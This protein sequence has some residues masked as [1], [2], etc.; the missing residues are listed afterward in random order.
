MMTVNDYY[1]NND[2]GDDETDGG[3]HRRRH[4]Q[5]H[6]HHR[7]SVARKKNRGGHAA[8]VNCQRKNDI[9]DDVNDV[10]SVEIDFVENENDIIPY[11]YPVKKGDGTRLDQNSADD[12]G[13]AI[14]TNFLNDVMT[15]KNGVRV[16]E[17]KMI[18]YLNLEYRGGLLNDRQIL[19]VAWS[20]YL[21]NYLHKVL[22]D[23]GEG[24]DISK[25]WDEIKSLGLMGPGF[26]VLTN[27]FER[28]FAESVALKKHA[29]MHDVMGA[30][31]RNLKVTNGYCYG[32]KR[33][34]STDRIK[35]SPLLGHITGIFKVL[36]NDNFLEVKRY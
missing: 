17:I 2:D 29:V 32:V 30:L 11:F 36:R 23:R 4:R 1:V 6:H 34:I 16:K 22:S 35:S 20:I 7:R 33:Y 28:I 21:Y 26:G 9:D 25:D 19:R 15:F 31:Y 3:R 14:I 8:I 13:D 10:C 5:Y 12:R 18:E 27:L 24:V